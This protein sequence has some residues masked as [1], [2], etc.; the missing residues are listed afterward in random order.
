MLQFSGDNKYGFLLS[1]SATD[2]HGM[3]DYTTG[4]AWVVHTLV[5]VVMIYNKET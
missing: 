1:A 3:K 5:A 4:W 2:N